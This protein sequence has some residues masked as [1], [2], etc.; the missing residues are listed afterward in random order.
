MFK[1]LLFDIIKFATLL[2]LLS[3]SF[4]IGVILLHNKNIHS[5]PRVSGWNPA[6]NL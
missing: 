2:L 6:G 4:N 3:F 1:T 5:M